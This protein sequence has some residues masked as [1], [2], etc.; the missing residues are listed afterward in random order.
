MRIFAWVLGIFLVALSVVP[1]L[2][3]TPTADPPLNLVGI[4]DSIPYAGFCTACEHAFVDDYAIRL[5]GQ[6]GR[7][8]TIINRSRND[9]AQLNQIADQVATEERLREQLASADLVIISAGFNDGPPWEADHPCGTPLGRSLR[10]DIDQMLAY[11]PDCLGEEVA[12][13]EEDFRTLFT[14]IDALV[15]ETASVVVV[16]AYNSATGWPE[17]AGYAT[18]AELAQIDQSLASFFDAWNAQECAVAAESGV[19]CV[20]LYHAFNG[21]DGMTPAGDLLELDYS[22]PSK[23]GNALI[24]DL[25]MAANL[26]GASSA[27][28]AASVGATPTAFARAGHPVVG[29][30]QWDDAQAAPGTTASNAL[31]NADGTYLEYLAG[32]G[33]GIGVWQPTGDDTAVI[34]VVYETPADLSALAVPRQSI[35][36]SLLSGTPQRMHLVVQVAGDHLT[37]TGTYLDDQGAAVPGAPYE[38]TA[39]RLALDGD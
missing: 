32:F 25:L 29:L 11:T 27:T 14:A 4:G 3:A 19:V 31:F 39:F 8:V 13:R 38:G 12:A 16:N 18:P 37:G 1:G 5:E 33:M 21:P 28:P 22:H 34:D 30:W 9:G 17:L 10:Q 23:Q 7:E 35:P 24:A 36:A 26:L 2:A 20:D 15:P 6:L